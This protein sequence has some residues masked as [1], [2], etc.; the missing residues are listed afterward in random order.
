MLGD[1]GSL[2]GEAIADRIL[3]AEIEGT[4]VG[5]VLVVFHSVRLSINGSLAFGRVTVCGFEA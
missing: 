4:D 1:I 5:D 3:Q 2:L